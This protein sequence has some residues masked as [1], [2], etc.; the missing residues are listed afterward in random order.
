MLAILQPEDGSKLTQKGLRVI[1][2]V[3]V[4]D[5]S[6]LDRFVYTVDGGTPMEMSH[7]DPW[8][9]IT[10]DDW[11]EHT[12]EVLAEDEAGNVATSISVFTMVDETKIS[13]GGSTGLMIIVLLAI[14]GAAI[15]VAYTYNRRFMPGLRSTAIHEGDGFEEEWD[16]PE[17]E[18][19]DDDNKPCG[20][21]VSP[22]DPVYLA[23]EEAKKGPTTPGPGELE[24]TELEMVEMPELEQV[25]L[26][27]E[28]RPEK[29]G[30]SEWD[31]F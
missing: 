28:L 16:H 14:V 5:S 22:D 4:S 30:D 2:G 19:C 24:G 11:G 23:R 3:D 31:E 27:E 26:P 9:N 17:L 8:V 7:R 6:K 10:L 29:G 1:L 12:I 21:K 18:A 20:L 13:T 25:D 15:V